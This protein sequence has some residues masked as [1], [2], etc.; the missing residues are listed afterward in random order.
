MDNLRLQNEWDNCD[1]MLQATRAHRDRLASALREI[2]SN[3]HVDCGTRNFATAA[4][5]ASGPD[6][7]KETSRRCVEIAAREVLASWDERMPDGQEAFKTNHVLDF[8]YWSPSASM[9]SSEAMA[10]LRAALA[11]LEDGE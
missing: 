10:K 9:V 1:E 6:M 11:Y 7:V 5:S 8:S 2:A 4:L 3:A